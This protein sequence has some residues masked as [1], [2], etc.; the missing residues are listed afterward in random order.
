[1]SLKLSYLFV[2]NYVSLLA[3]APLA[4]RVSYYEYIVIKNGVVALPSPEELLPYL[5]AIQTAQVVEV[6]Y[7]AL[8]LVRVSPAMTAL[9]VGG[10]NLVVWAVMRAFPE[11]I[12]ASLGGRYCF[13]GCLL[14]WASSDIPRH[15]IFVE[16][17]TKGKRWMRRFCR[18]E[19]HLFLLA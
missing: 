5:T 17:W 9:Q 4:V 7:A 18:G 10:R 13:L 15:T 12:F 1:M 19:A 6:L 14:A 11:I 8:G 2:Y 3:W 16:Q